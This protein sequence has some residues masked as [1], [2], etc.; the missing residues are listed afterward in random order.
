MGLPRGREWG[1]REEF[2]NCGRNIAA[3]ACRRIWRILLWQGGSMGACF[4]WIVS[5]L[6]DLRCEEKGILTASDIDSSQEDGDV[7]IVVS[8]VSLNP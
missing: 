5:G 8:G 2:R 3:P 1:T 7:S 6:F 4:L